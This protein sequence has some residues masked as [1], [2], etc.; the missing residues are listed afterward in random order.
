MEGCCVER[1]PEANTV[2]SLELQ[3]GRH[4]MHA[5]SFGS[6]DRGA[7][8]PE[9]WLCSGAGHFT[10]D[11]VCI[12][13]FCDINGVPFGP[14]NLLQPGTVDANKFQIRS[15]VECTS[16]NALFEENYMYTVYVCV[17]KYVDG[18]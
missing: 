17:H 14:Q 3:L 12:L 4:R 6:Q 16:L 10:F 11:D 5:Y 13:F 1:S 9:V 18:T 15:R 7:S 8:Q 2:S